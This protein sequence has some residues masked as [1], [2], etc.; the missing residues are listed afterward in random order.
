MNKQ[1]DPSPGFDEG[2]LAELKGMVAERAASLE[3]DADADRNSWSVWR[4]SPRL[5]TGGA[6]AVTAV[7]TALFV[8]AGGQGSSPAY[9]VEAQDGG[10]VSVQVSELSDAGGFEA[11][12]EQAGIPADVT[13]L[14]A[15]MTC[16]RSG[17]QAFSGRSLIAGFPV[18]GA[19]NQAGP[20]T[21]ELNPHE[22]LP[23][24]TLI[25]T[26]TLGPDQANCAGA[27]LQVQ[28]ATGKVPPCDPVAA[29]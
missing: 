21:F 1:Q 22:L 3:D 6:V 17:L 23:D 8:S 26:A 11:A 2:L 7:L 16:S 12:L 9:A 18:D 13:Y 25:V 24:Q 27:S 15:G 4:R 28:I 20:V 19:G 10:L 5:L 14:P 29:S